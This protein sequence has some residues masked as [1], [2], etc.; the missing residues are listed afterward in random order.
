MVVVVAGSCY[1][2]TLCGW[3]SVS[4]LKD[5]YASTSAPSGEILMW[6]VKVSQFLAKAF[7]E[8][9]RT[10][11]LLFLPFAVNFAVAG[12]VRFH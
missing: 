3:S 6:K 7:F 4:S 10:G 2:F 5:A 1:L 12:R 9:G 11:T 8:C